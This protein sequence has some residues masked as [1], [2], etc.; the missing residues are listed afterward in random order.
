MR[1][2]RAVVVAGLALVVTAACGAAATAQESVNVTVP[3]GVDF[4]VTDVSRETAGAPAPTRIPARDPSPE[5][6]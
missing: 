4:Y 3:A 5:F 1:I 6:P 2:G